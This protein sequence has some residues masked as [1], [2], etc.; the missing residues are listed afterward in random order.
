VIGGV[1]VASAVL[2]VLPPSRPVT[3][4]GFRPFAALKLFLYFSW[5][6][7][8]AS[9]Y[10]AWE[11]VTPRNRINAAVI[12]VTL[13]TRIPGVATA[14][15][16]MVSLT[17]GTV[18]LEVDEDTMTLYM[19][20]LHLHSIEETRESV[21]HLERLTLDAFPPRPSPIETRHP[22]ERR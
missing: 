14:V 2:Y 19:H 18:T 11:V 22:E 7:I 4:V 17:P 5:K 16:S 10:L 15:A 1:L 6:L 3:Q 20:V 12:S 13:R 21:R 8:E 9:A